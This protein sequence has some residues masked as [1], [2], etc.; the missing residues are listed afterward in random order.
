MAAP[1]DAAIPIKNMEAMKAKESELIQNAENIHIPNWKARLDIA[2]GRAVEILLSFDKLMGTESDPK[3]RIKILQTM[4]TG[5]RGVLSQGVAMAKMETTLPAVE[6]LIRAFEAACLDSGVRSDIVQKIHAIEFFP[7]KSKSL[8][9]VGQTLLY[10]CQPELGPPGI[11]NKKELTDFFEI[12]FYAQERALVAKF[13]THG[14]PGAQAR[15]KN[16]LSSDIQLEFDLVSL[17]D[18]CSL[19]ENRVP[20]ARTVVTRTKLTDKAAIAIGGVVGA[21]Q[22]M[23]EKNRGAHQDQS[24]P[25]PKQEENLDFSSPNVIIPLVEAFEYC[26]SIEEQ[27]RKAIAE[28]ISKIVVVMVP[29][30]KLTGSMTLHQNVGTAV[31]SPS[32]RG[33]PPIKDGVMMYKGCFE[34]GVKG[35]FTKNDVIDFLEGHFRCREKAMVT[36]L[37]SGPVP[38]TNERLT[39]ILGKNIVTEVT[40]GSILH[41]SLDMTQRLEICNL[42]TEGDSKLV[43]GVLVSAIDDVI[44]KKDDEILAVEATSDNMLKERVTRIVL[45]A[46]PGKQ[47]K[48]SLHFNKLDDDKLA[49]VYTCAFERGIRGVFDFY[50][51][52]HELRELCGLP[53]PANEKGVKGVF[54]KA[55]SSASKLSRDVGNASRDVAKK[56]GRMFGKLLS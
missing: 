19:H 40:W 5:A 4:A 23:I 52:K 29:G 31:I 21:A 37:M 30:A 51:F 35:C 38:L 32:Q 15:L 47:G 3:I 8:T 48:P 1:N 56:M 33:V 53:T 43:L 20:T 42:L 2:A 39:Q 27:N 24:T 14:L 54:Q 22:A 50:E 6:L 49:L 10:T 11:F 26:C 25:T 7:G 17:L 41:A 45:T 34:A 44:L 18:Q 55:G 36:K 9:F 16:A 12:Q 28:A 13:N 46:T